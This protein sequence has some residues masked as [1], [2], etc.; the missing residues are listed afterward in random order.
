MTGKLRA[1]KMSTRMRDQARA[2]APARP[3]IATRTVTGWRS[4][5]AMG[6]TGR[7]LG[8]V[9]PQGYQPAAAMTARGSG[10][11]KKI[12]QEETE[13]TE[14]DKSREK[15]PGFFSLCLPLSSPFPLFPPVQ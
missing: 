10:G 3:T 4:A 8:W 6:F 13:R 14:R 15:R 5:N 12:L 11:K 7:L 9:R 2:P 1:G